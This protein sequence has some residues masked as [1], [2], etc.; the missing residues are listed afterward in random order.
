LMDVLP[1]LLAQ[2]Q[3]LGL[4]TVTLSEALPHRHLPP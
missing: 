2:C 3:A 4:Q 1:P